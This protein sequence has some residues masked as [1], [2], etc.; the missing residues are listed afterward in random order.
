MLLSTEMLLLVLAL[1][2]ESADLDDHAL[3]LQIRAGNRQAFKHFFD[4]HHEALF[5]FLVSRGFDHADAEELIQ[6]AFVQLWEKR[7]TIREG[8]SLRSFLFTIAWN[9]ALNIERDRRKFDPNA[10]VFTESET[11]LEPSAHE[12]LEGR[13]LFGQLNEAIKN[14]PEKRREVFEMCFVHGTPYK[15]AAAA[16]NISVKTVE[17]QMGHALKAIRAALRRYL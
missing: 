13:E 8:L 12:V 5:R 17:N 6:Q 16:L 15:E 11:A 9:R 3:A 7:E 2:S 14:L 4:R 10:S 1:A